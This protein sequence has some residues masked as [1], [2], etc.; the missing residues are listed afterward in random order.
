LQQLA[1]L[2]EHPESVPINRLVAVKGTPLE[3]S[4][5]IDPF[6]FI[7]VIAVTRVLMPKS[8]IRLAA[9]RDNMNDELHALCFFAGANS[10]FNSERLLT[11]QNPTADRNNS[12]LKRLNIAAAENKE[13]M[14]CKHKH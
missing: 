7:R 13:K 1:N 8:V 9:G 3:K 6:E 2:P 12:I 10:I 5:E 4:V 14:L 11:T